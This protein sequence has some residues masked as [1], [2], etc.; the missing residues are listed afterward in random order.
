MLS[1]SEKRK[2]NSITT[3]FIISILPT[4]LIKALKDKLIAFNISVHEFS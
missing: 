4:V 1:K 2:A 3:Y